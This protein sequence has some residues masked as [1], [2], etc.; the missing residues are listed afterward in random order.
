M[1]F[2]KRILVIDDEEPICRM[3]EKILVSAGGYVVRIETN[4]TKAIS[5]ATSFE[6]DLILLDIIMPG[7]E[8]PEISKLLLRDR[9]LKKVPVVFITGIL[10]DDDVGKREGTML[11]RPCI[12]KPITKV[13][14]LDC[15]REQLG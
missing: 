15:V 11:N 9:R 12:A 13:K 4:G 6:P 10:T 7:V 1:A 8:G 5:A 2:T 14:L 3:I